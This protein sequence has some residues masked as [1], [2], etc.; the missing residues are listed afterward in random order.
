[1]AP[2]DAAW[3]ER[4]VSAMVDAASSALAAERPVAMRW[5]SGAVAGVATNRDHPET[6]ADIS[7]DLLILCDA[8][9]DAPSAILGSFPAHPTVMSAANLEITADLPGAFRRSLASRLGNAQPWIA[10]ATGAA[11]DI[12]SRHVRRGQDFVELD[13]LGDVLAARAERIIQQATMV[14][15]DG[16]AITLDSRSVRIPVAIKSFP[17][18]ADLAAEE[19]QLRAAQPVSPGEARTI[20]T[21]LQGVD[22]ARR[23]ARKAHALPR[24]AELN[25]LRIGPV[26]LVTVPGELYNAL[27]ARLRSATGHPVMVIGYAN[28]HVGYLPSADAYAN[29][30]YEVLT[31]PVVLGTAE[32]LVS[33]LESELESLFKRQ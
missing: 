24:V 26:A 7:L 1:Y 18:E 8:G 9:T 25:A 15:P 29:M 6:P 27:G 2:V 11:A 17:S 23:L 14:I 28:G 19:Q 33:A 10:L 4:L 12:S 21:A 16:Q 3:N 32:R 31:S 13:R 20:E 30:D 5:A 22:G